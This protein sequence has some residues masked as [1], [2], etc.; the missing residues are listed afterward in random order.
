MKHR[1]FHPAN[2]SLDDDTLDILTDIIAAGSLWDLISLW[3][4]TRLLRGARAMNGTQRPDLK[5]L[6]G[7]MLDNIG[8]AIPLVRMPL[9]A[10]HPDAVWQPDRGYYAESDEAF[11]KRIAEHL[12]RNSSR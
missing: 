3:F 8:S 1:R 7:S 2:L 4:W 10:D 6:G 12:R 9:D 5:P 11:R